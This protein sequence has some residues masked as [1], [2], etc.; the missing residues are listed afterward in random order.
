MSMMPG[1][2]TSFR[3]VAYAFLSTM[4]LTEEQVD[5]LENV[6]NEEEDPLEGSRG[7]CGTTALSCNPGSTLQVMPRRLR[8]SY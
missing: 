3:P 2:N 8:T 4:K 7:G 1:S 5:D 6:I